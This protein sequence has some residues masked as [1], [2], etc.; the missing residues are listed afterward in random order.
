MA[1][2]TFRKVTIKAFNPIEW[3]RSF[4]KL[5]LFQRLDVAARAECRVGTDRIDARVEVRFHRVDNPDHAI[6]F[7]RTVDNLGAV[8]VQS[9][10]LD[11]RAMDQLMAQIV[12]K[13]KRARVS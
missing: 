7:R 5:L 3:E 9:G 6:L 10:Q 12:R 2:S 13:R 1:A 4:P 11:D 8:D